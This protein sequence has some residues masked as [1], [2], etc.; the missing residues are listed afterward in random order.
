MARALDNLATRVR[1]VR[2][3]KPPAH[4]HRQQPGSDGG[5]RPELASLAIEDP[6][7]AREE[8]RYDQ[9][10]A[11]PSP[12]SGVRPSRNV[13]RA[14]SSRTPAARSLPSSI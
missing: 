9:A 13:R 12:I 11:R 4:P 10:S 14:S 7:Y 1:L 5:S 6:S 2:R 3:S 8:Q